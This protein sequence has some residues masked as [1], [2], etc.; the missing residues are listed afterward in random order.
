MTSAVR[1]RDISYASRYPFDVTMRYRRKSGVDTEFQKLT[2][3]KASMFFYGFAELLY[4]PSDPAKLIVGRWVMLDMKRIL[5][6]WVRVGIDWGVREKSNDVDADGRAGSTFVTFS[7]NPIVGDI[8][9]ECVIAS[10]DGYFE[11]VIPS[12]SV[13]R[14]TWLDEKPKRPIMPKPPQ[15]SLW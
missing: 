12:A 14:P 6:H 8:G 2:D 9:R 11:G 13:D 4:P 5:G 15:G 7:T 1:I 10:S 3:G